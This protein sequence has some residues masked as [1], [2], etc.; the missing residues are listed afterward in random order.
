MGQIPSEG[1]DSA[2]RSGLLHISRTMM[3]YIRNSW[4][5]DM[6]QKARIFRKIPW[7][8]LAWKNLRFNL[9]LTGSNYKLTTSVIVLPLR[10]I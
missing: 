1:F 7:S 8:F 4:N 10:T 6:Q 2:V 5:A 9:G 3:G